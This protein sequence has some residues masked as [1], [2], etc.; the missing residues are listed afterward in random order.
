MREVT[1][2]CSWE[3]LLKVKLTLLAVKFSCGS[4]RMSVPVEIFCGVARLLESVSR[5][6]SSIGDLCYLMMIST[7]PSSF[8]S[9][10]D[11]RHSTYV[12][13]R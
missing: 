8:N 11:T 9:R 12:Y 7:C 4:L 3:D 1:A 10:R 13:G 5:T 6:D 2:C